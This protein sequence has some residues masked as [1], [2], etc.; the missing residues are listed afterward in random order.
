MV[1]EE[2]QN[3]YLEVQ[4]SLV[5]NGK[6]MDHVSANGVFKIQTH[7]SQLKL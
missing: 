7:V 3:R 4:S 1:N 5:A 2:L 6:E